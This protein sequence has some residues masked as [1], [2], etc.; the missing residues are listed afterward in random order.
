M[1]GEIMRM[2][3]SDRER[4]A[5]RELEAHFFASDVEKGQGWISSTT[6]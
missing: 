6:W 2:K 5:T 1:A 3:Y 4:N